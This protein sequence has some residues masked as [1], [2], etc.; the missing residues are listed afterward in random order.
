MCQYSGFAC[1]NSKR[2]DPAG[3]EPSLIGVQPGMPPPSQLDEK[4]HRTGAPVAVA[5]VSTYVPVAG[6]AYDGFEKK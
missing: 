4:L 2:T 6:R 3:A 1:D 5:G